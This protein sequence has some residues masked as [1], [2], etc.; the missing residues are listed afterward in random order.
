ML[1]HGGSK[2]FRIFVWTLLV[3]VICGIAAAF[4]Y[5]KFT[6]SGLPYF[7]R[8]LPDFTLS[9]STGWRL[10]LSDLKGKVWVADFI[11]TS[12]GS[13]C[14]VITRTMSELQKRVKE[15]R[16]VRLVSFTVD[17]ATDTPDV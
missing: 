1:D 17:P 7:S 9:D 12:C 15:M 8:N 13:T 14:P 6:A 3:V 5:Q 4:T 10:S 11:F 2:R 16:D